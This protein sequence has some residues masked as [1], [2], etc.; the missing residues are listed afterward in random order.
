[1][2]PRVD[3]FIYEPVP[4]L[5]RSNIH[6]KVTNSNGGTLIESLRRGGKNE[7]G[8]SDQKEIHHKRPFHESEQVCVDT[9]EKHGP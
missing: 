6:T 2:V 9:V 4:I 1:M 8:E 3:D 5:V 7:H